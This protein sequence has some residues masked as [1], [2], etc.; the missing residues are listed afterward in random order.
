MNRCQRYL[1]RAAALGGLAL[2]LPSAPGQNRSQYGS[3][4][5]SAPRASAS[6]ARE[7]MVITLSGGVSVQT[8][9]G[10]IM[11]ASTMTVAL[12]T[13]PATKKTDARTVSVSGSV[14]LKTV[15]SVAPKG[16]AAFKRVINAAADHMVLNNFQHTVVLTGNVTVSA[17]DPSATYSWRN[18]ARATVNLAT[19]QIEADAPSGEKMNV[20]MK[21]KG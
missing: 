15:Q 12:D 2:V 4:A 17:D 6:F 11:T 18:A 13:N 1:A 19:M 3:I 8:A 5:A 14:R 10:D 21:P 7:N 9:G 20:D 16:G